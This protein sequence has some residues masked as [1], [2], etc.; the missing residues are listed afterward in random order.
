MRVVD[1]DTC[2]RKNDN[3]G[4]LKVDEKNM[5]CVGEQ[6]SSGCQVNSSSIMISKIIVNFPVFQSVPT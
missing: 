3:I 6:G 5:F 1:H 2:A 4:N